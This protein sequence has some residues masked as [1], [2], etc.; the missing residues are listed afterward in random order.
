MAET[1]PNTLVLRILMPIRDRGTGLGVRIDPRSPEITLSDSLD[2][3]AWTFL[4]P[5]RGN[6]VFSVSWFFTDS[7]KPRT[8]GRGLPICENVLVELRGPLTLSN[9]CSVRLVTAGREVNGGG[10]VCGSEAAAKNC[11]NSPGES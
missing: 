11:V 4:V 8:S 5:A 10:S 7:E 2:P 3:P 1:P 9:F 6:V